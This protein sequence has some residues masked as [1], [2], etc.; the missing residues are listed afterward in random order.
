MNRPR[1]LAVQNA[2]HDPLG[3]LATCM[4][5]IEVETVRIYDGDPVPRAAYDG[6]VVLGGSMAA[7]DPTGW[8]PDV[9]E[10]LARAV[11]DGIP[12]LGICLGAQLLAMACGGEVEVSAEPGR[13]AGVVDIGWRAEASSDP[14][15]AGLP[16][17]YPGPSWHVDAVSELPPAA[18][19]LG[20]SATYP[21]QAFRVGEAAW[22]LQFHPEV[23][24]NDY[25]VWA[26]RV[27]GPVEAAAVASYEAREHEVESAGRVL[28]R[29][30]AALCG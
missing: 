11:A 13:E 7:D 21:H 9:Q 3:A 23:S 25:R 29:R 22:G 5:G 16:D 10:L 30:F 24:L 1:V 19:W 17:P 6:L 20:A 12:T 28:A 14:L 8:L 4:D 26:S 18:V 27:G 2:P 15:V